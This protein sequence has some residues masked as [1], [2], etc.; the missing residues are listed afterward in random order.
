MSKIQK[1]IIT[2]LLIQVF[3]IL[4]TWIIFKL[5]INTQIFLFVLIYFYFSSLLFLLICIY[6]IINILR[7]KNIKFGILVIIIILNIQ[8]IFFIIANYILGII[9][10]F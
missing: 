5:V 3:I 2:M 9:T 7:K 10:L 4:L 1:A 8:T 6:L